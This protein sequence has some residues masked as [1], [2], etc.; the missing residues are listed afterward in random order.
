[1][2]TVSKTFNQHQMFR[3]SCAKTQHN[4]AMNSSNQIDVTAYSGTRNDRPQI[5][6][7]ARCL[8]CGYCACKHC[9]LIDVANE[10]EGKEVKIS[11]LN[12]EKG[13]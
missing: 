2:T 13:L 7:G 1:M 4:W 5:H 8:T 6:V 10:C 11:N 12:N 9:E 3:E